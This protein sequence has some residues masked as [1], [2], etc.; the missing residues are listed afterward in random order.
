MAVLL[1]GEADF[2]S[3]VEEGSVAKG[4]DHVR[5]YHE[6]PRR[7]LDEGRVRREGEKRGKGGGGGGDCRRFEEERREP[8]GTRRRPVLSHR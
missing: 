8:S 1:L 2:L 5:P 7:F 6:P 3:R 4:L